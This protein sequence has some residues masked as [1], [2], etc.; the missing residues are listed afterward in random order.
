ML[1]KLEVDGFKNLTNFEI[2]LGPYTCIAG[3]NSVGKSNIFDAIRFL[4]STADKSFN[5]AAASLR[6]DG[7]PGNIDD[8]FGPSIIGPNLMKI[9]AEM[10][11]PSEHVD[12][13]NRKVVATS[14]FL[15]YE[16]TLRLNTETSSFGLPITN[17]VL[18][19]ESLTYVPK[20]KASQKI[21]WLKSGSVFLESAVY[22]NRRTGDFIRTVKN[23]GDE[24]VEIAQ[25]GPAANGGGRSRGKPSPIPIGDRNTTQSAL[26]AFGSYD[27]PTVFA[28]KKELAAWMILALEPSSM[29][30]PSLLTDY[31][32]LD[33]RGGNIP[34]TVFSLMHSFGEEDFLRSLA[35]STSGLVDV[36]KID[37]DVD[38]RRQQITLLG[39]IGSDPLLPA[40]SLSDGTL[41]FLALCIL[42]MDPRSSGL[43]CMEEPE[44]GIH[45]GKITE[46]YRLL[47]DLAVDPGAEI[48]D[49]NPLRQVIVNT[50]SPSYV[51]QHDRNISSILMAEGGT[52]ALPD[53]RRCRTVRV[54]AVRSRRRSGES[55]IALANWRSTE[56]RGVSLE[57]IENYLTLGIAGSQ[58]AIDIVPSFDAE[59]D[60]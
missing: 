13:F 48:S 20:G 6:S 33:A 21:G 40:A 34:K 3:P 4:S 35:V 23:N 12:D 14:T 60:R 57:K 11:V 38:E 49:R 15:R 27:Y 43:I 41:R 50:H 5:D 25:D 17:I 24:R 10:I 52:V 42:E 39:K 26:R 32:R 53:G 31:D 19:E 7:A 1:T 30:A 44:N 2:E 9:C 51:A 47:N 28:A 56:K 29:R 45:P 58:L 46:M 22:N 8:I 59:M 37:V 54:R 55:R 36:R 16:L 18:E